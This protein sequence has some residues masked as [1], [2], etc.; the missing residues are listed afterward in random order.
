MIFHLTDFFRL[1]LEASWQSSLI[2]LL[3]LLVRPLMGA[4]VPARWRYLLWTLVL[5][6][7]LV[8][9]TVF[10]SNPVSI[11]N[12]AVV[13]QPFEQ[14]T[15]TLLRTH[16]VEPQQ[17]PPSEGL[18]IAQPVPTPRQLP[19]PSWPSSIPW[20]TLTAAIWL[21][22]M[23]ISLGIIIGAQVMLWRRL[24]EN[25]LRVDP[26]VFAIWHECCQRLR[27]KVSPILRTSRDVHSPAL[28]GLFRPV[29]LL[30][31]KNLAA[32]SPEDWE[33]IFAHELAHYC[34]ADQWSHLVQ[35][36]AMAVHW[37]NPVVWFGFRQLRADREL[38][39]D[40]WALQ[41]LE[42]ER[43]EGYG[44]TLLKV[45][46]GSSGTNLSV[47]AVGILEDRVQLKQRLQR[48]VGFGP[49]TLLGSLLG[50][51]IVVVMAVLVLGR[52]S[53]EVDL[54]NYD[55][56][57]PEEILGTAAQRGDIP[58]MRQ[59]LKDGVNINAIAAVEG[60]Q[61]ALSAAAEAGQ[62]ESLRFLLSRGA[63]I[64]EKADQVWPPVHA[65]MES[66][67][68][69]CANYLLSQGAICDPDIVAAFKGEMAEVQAALAK[70]PA[71]VEK[72]KTMCTVAATNGHADAFRL[73][74]EKIK[75]QPGQSYWQLDDW[76]V[77]FVIAQGH[78][79]VLQAVLDESPFAQKLNKGSVMRLSRAAAQSPGMRDWLI[80]KGFTIPEYNDGERLIEAADQ[81]DVAEMKRLVK[82]G[83][84]INYRGESSWTP[85]TRAAGS[86]QMGSVKFL[87]AHGADP[88]SVHLP[89]WDYSAICMTSKPEVADLLLAA[90]GNINAT[91]F[92]RG[93]HIMDYNVIFGP[94]EM[95]KWYLA[96]GVDPTK[97]QAERPDR[98]FLFDAG[99]PEIAE[100]LIQH[101]VD[102][103][104]KDK[105]GITALSWICMFGREP[106]ETAR[107]L[108]KHG[109]DP[110][111][112]DKIG[113]TPLMRA[114]DG[115][116]VDALVEYGADV[117]AKTKDGQSL[118]SAGGTYSDPTW[119][120]ALI[121]HGAT[122]DIKTDGPTQ[123]M[124]AAWM[125]QLD[126]MAALLSERV[127][128]NLKG[129]WNKAANDYMTPLTAA[130]VAGHY[131]AA[132]LLVD[133]GAKIDKQDMSTAL[134]N[135]RVSIVK[136]FWEHGAHTISPLTYAVSQGASV[137]EL[138]KLVDQGNPLNT[139]QGENSPLNEAA[140]LGNL[141]AVQFLVEKE[142]DIK[143]AGQPDPKWFQGIEGP[144]NSAASEGQDEIVT[145]LLQHGAQA[146]Y[147]DVVEAANN[148]TPY[149]DER[150]KDHFEKTVKLLIDASA[151]KGI[152]A[153][154]SAEVLQ[155]A[156]FTRQG[157]GNQAVV[158]MLLD[159]GL[160]LDTP[161]K[162]GKS[163]IQIA[164]EN[165]TRTKGA[166]PPKDLMAF[167][168][169]A[170]KK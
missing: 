51:C 132:K 130:V 164:R 111:A 36:I 122:Y 48:I 67:H 63:D 70:E 3:V 96:H 72:L 9:I 144:L 71:D 152:S 92:K 22:G 84:D 78:R 12:I 115:A 95:V 94:T 50:L 159:A 127:D 60:K 18:G 161:G 52:P 129:L 75:T 25:Q 128:P 157:P 165:S 151:L 133:H 41:H 46:A 82:K 155:S 125:N 57:K 19:V 135:R 89:G 53:E 37:F 145:Y 38:A 33:N 153:E 77:L 154:N 45:L 137:Q 138:A 11:Q 148:S 69:E 147:G 114:R 54:S 121:R 65:A 104:A 62:M 136:L 126:V 30:P 93:V 15:F 166:L 101:G 4:S 5:V 66:G 117:H 13:D 156:I 58:V 109:A 149:P 123:L 120:Q 170:D 167:L 150:T 56:L 112:R 40:E 86:N 116:T 81:G 79:D 80:S 131:D 55:S 103:N 85:I 34:R 162:D 90:G 107:V 106:A 118:L 100:L 42:P 124:R 158:K 61:P 163:A 49:R 139:P 7:L 141:P 28:V 142:A 59:M 140:L 47:A 64:N 31:E 24:E 168:E 76:L 29:L 1:V 88:N 97:V 83:V 105:D 74:L 91:L 169:Q 98:T 110:N 26:A 99:N 44:D 6:R 134:F 23:L 21:A 14:V 20:W 39:A 43:S 8:P 87:L 73:I 2:I 102:V 143:K 68:A 17:N 108:L 119:M 16:G 160:S 27:I 32:F 146:N 113:I 35:L 10:P